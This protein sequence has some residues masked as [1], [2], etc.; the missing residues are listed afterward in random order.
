MSGV[1]PYGTGVGR[2]IVYDISAKEGAVT[3]G[4]LL[5][6]EAGSEHERNRRALAVA[7]EFILAI[8]GDASWLKLTGCSF[9]HIAQLEEHPSQLWH[10]PAFR[11]W[12]LPKEGCPIP[13]LP[14]SR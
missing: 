7:K 9:C 4:V 5:P 2:V 10:L 12:I 11:A 14:A 13:P 1:I 8:G 6:Q 3:F